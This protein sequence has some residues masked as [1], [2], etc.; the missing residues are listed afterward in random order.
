MEITAP[1]IIPITGPMAIHNPMFSV[2]RPI[3]LPMIMPTIKLIP[4]VC[5]LISILKLL[6]PVALWIKRGITF[7]S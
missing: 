6:S 5:A 1:A 3:T 2:K 4:I 7:H